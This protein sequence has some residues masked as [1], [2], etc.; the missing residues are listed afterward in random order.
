MH[1]ARAKT[2]EPEADRR[3]EILRA[4]IV[5]FAAK[6]Y[7]GCRIADVAKQAGVAYGLVYHYFKNKEELLASVFDASFGRFAHAVD[8]LI[9]EEQS[10]AATLEQIVDFAFRAY[11]ADPLSVRVLIFEIVRSP[12][13][14]EASRVSALQ[15]TMEATAR[16]I[17]K[18]QKSGEM[19]HDVEPFIASS[20][21]YG[22]IETALTT[23]V[24]GAVSAQSEAG[25]EKAKHD[26]LA[27][28][29]QG[30]APRAQVHG[31]KTPALSRPA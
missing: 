28:F 21:L 24:L 16:L 10:V 5:V 2:P 19:R 23:F 1:R 4:A 27:V 30:M 12:A 8:A 22:A 14:R 25:V 26:L 11:V 17:A 29:L 18:G 20:M 7:H 3:R 9:A 15:H 6:G 13:F 31:L